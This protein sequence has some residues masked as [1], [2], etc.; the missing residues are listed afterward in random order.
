MRFRG[1]RGRRQLRRKRLFHE[2]SKYSDPL[3]NI[4]ER[5]L[6]FDPGERPTSETLLKAVQKYMTAPVAG[7]SDYLPIGDRIAEDMQ[8]YKLRMNLDDKYGIRKRL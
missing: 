5:C 7:I 3:I 4:V 6:R 1:T 2:K 8:H